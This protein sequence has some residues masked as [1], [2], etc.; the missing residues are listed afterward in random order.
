MQCPDNTH[1]ENATVR[2]REGVCAT[3][4]TMMQA[5]SSTFSCEAKLSHCV[6]LLPAAAFHPDHN[7]EETEQQRKKQRK[8]L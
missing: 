1:K 7:K 8:A 2:S 5:M 6:I 3:M 4:H